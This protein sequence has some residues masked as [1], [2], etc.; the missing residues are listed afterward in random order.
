MT[1]SYIF[2]VVMLSAI[3]LNIFKIIEC[4][5]KP[6]H[7]HPFEM[8]SMISFILL[9]GENVVSYS[10]QLSNDILK[11]TAARNWCKQ[12]DG[13][14][15][16]FDLAYLDETNIDM[17]FKKLPEGINEVWI[18]AMIAEDGA[19]GR[20]YQVIKKFKKEFKIDYLQS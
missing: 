19:G 16:F 2:L 18:G 6:T 1:S 5:G 3:L 10:Y 17:I 9:L 15:A 14:L 8:Y 12:Q 13:D 7:S 4:S 11:A 20:Q